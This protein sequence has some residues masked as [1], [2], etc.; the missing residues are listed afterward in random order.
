MS[1][2]KFVEHGLLEAV[3][4]ILPNFCPYCSP[5]WEN[6]KNGKNREREMLDY[7]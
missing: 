7:F 3:I 4:H 5:A 6:L 1:G 2:C